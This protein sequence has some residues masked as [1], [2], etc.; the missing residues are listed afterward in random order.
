M[1]NLLWKTIDKTSITI[2]WR[3]TLK[4]SHYVLLTFTY[5]ATLAQVHVEVR[6]CEHQLVC[7]GSEIKS[8]T[9]SKKNTNKRCEEDFVSWC[10]LWI[11]DN[12]YKRLHAGQ[13]HLD[14]S[15]Y[16]TALSLDTSL[17]PTEVG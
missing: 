9:D 5:D 15:A 7:G 3:L 12:I 16:V 17:D 10:G 2:F 4:I 1:S 11:D 6:I 8:N 14:T 13:K